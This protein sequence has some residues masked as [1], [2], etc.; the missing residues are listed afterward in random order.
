M[1][2]SLLVFIGLAMLA[3]G[4]DSATDGAVRVDAAPTETTSPV[5]APTRAE[6]PPG[7]SATV[8]R[9]EDGD[10]I[11]AEVGG[12][13]ERV[14]LIGINTPERD[15]CLGD[16]ARETLS[17]MIE[18]RSVLLES[19]VEESD[20]YGRLLAYVWIDGTLVNAEMV[21][22]GVAIA[23]AFRPNTSRQQQLESA[24]EEAVD[25][26]R[27][28]WDP[29]ACGGASA[30]DLEIV[31]IT[32]NPA[33]RDEED[34]NGEFVVIRNNGPDADLTGYVLRDGSSVNRFLFPDGFV[35]ASGS[36]VTVFVGCGGDGINELYWCASGPVWDNAG[37][38]A[39]LTEPA[40]GF[41]AIFE[42][43]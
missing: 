15:E 6:N 26:G 8:V 7:E 39:F 11:F 16:V 35:L 40:G 30:A 31:G 2:R 33:G 4:C 22:A 38:Q 17:D 12:R 42:Y 14:R 19:D 29:T 1:P 23:R 34:L 32:E 20:Q 9:V 41:I 36:E 21:R 5:S 13:E 25:A 27:G 28:L 24:E 37:D 10:S 43:P 18:G 3:A